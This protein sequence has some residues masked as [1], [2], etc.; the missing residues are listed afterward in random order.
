ME[1]LTIE[2][3][4]TEFGNQLSGFIC[5]KT[6]H[7]DHCHDILQEVSIKIIQNIEKV[8]KAE[9]IGAYLNRMANNA[10]IDFYRRESPGIRF[11]E[12][13]DD[14]A[15]GS[16]AV[17]VTTAI[18]LADCCLRPMIE[19]L[20][21]LYSEALILTEL[22]GMSQKQLAE[23][24]GISG[25]GA[26]SRVQRARLM[27]KEVILNCCQYEFDKYGNIISCCGN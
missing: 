16:V 12:L 1:V 25:S 11:N 14:I 18:R 26:R 9:N 19:S 20:P 15:D 8:Q 4:W 22:E 21:P 17:D 6:G 24:L 7:Q 23:K 3:I 2:K 13:E 27:L 10:V 5:K